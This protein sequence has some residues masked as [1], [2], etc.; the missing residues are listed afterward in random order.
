MEA[1][2]VKTSKRPIKRKS[3]GPPELPLGMSF[4]TEYEIK[5]FIIREFRMMDPDVDVRGIVLERYP[6]RI[7]NWRLLRIQSNDDNDLVLRFMTGGPHVKLQNGLYLVDK[8]P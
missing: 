6:S 1:E 7:P 8:K 3:P 4:A 2:M 5:Q